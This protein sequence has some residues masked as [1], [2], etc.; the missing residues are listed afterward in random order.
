MHFLTTCLWH[1]RF[2]T[3]ASFRFFI[4]MNKIPFSPKN[5]IWIL[6]IDFKI[7]MNIKLI[8]SLIVRSNSF[9]LNLDFSEPDGGYVWVIT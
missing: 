4:Y 2:Q 8:S 5:Y 9:Q 6:Q 1:G 3:S 7:N